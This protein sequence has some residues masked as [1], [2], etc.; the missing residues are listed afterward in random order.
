MIIM[1]NEMDNYTNDA[2]FRVLALVV[3]TLL[4]LVFMVTQCTV[5]NNKNDF[6]AHV[7]CIESKGNWVV[8]GSHGYG[9]CER[10]KS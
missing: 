4:L 7:K 1:D 6:K 9:K 5:T 3:I 10:V 8:A 2:D